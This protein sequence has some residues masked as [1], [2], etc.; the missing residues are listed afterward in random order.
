MKDR[1]ELIELLLSLTDDERLEL[2]TAFLSDRSS[3]RK[4]APPP[5]RP[6]DS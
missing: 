1:T 6:R 4:E 5:P 3:Q 2:L